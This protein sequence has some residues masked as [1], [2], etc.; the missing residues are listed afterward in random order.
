MIAWMFRKVNGKYL[1]F[2]PAF[3]AIREPPCGENLGSTEP[4]DY[5][6]AYIVDEKFPVIDPES[7]TTRLE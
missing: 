5:P 2:V 3:V 6:A 7:N 1:N 4:V